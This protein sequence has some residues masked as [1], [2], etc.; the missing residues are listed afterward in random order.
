MKRKLLWTCLFGT[1]VVITGCGGGGGGGGGVSPYPTPNPYLRTEVPYSVPVRVGTVDPL[2]NNS[3]QHFVGDTYTANISGSGQDVIIAG[4]MTQQSSSSDWANT[5]LRMFSWNNGTLVDRTAQWFPDNSN[6]IVGANNVQFADF[7]KS[8][9]TDMVTAPYS[10]W[11]LVNNGPAYV[12]TNRGNSFTRQTLVADVSAHDFAVADVN[13]DGY[14]DIVILDANARNSTLAINDQISSF[15]TYRATTGAQLSGSSL[16]VADFLNNNTTTLITTDNWSANGQVQKLWSWG[17]DSGNNLQWNELATLPTSRFNL[18][19]WKDI[20]ILDSHNVKVSAHD[21]NRDNVMDAIVFSQPGRVMPGTRTDYSEIQFLRN[22]GAGS[23]TDVTDST[24]VGYNTNTRSTY[25]PKF[26]DLNGDGLIDILVSGSDNAG[27]S[28]QF[29]L[30]SADG[31]YVASHAKVLTDYLKQVRDM[32]GGDSFN[33]TVN[34]VTAPDGK[35]HLVSAVSFMNGNDRQLAV[36]LSALGSQSV[37]T[38]QTAVNLMLQK[39]PYMTVAQANDALARTVATYI[40]GVPV[41][42]EDD[43]FKPVGS[44]GLATTRGTVPINGFIAGLNLGDA[45]VIALD[46]VGRSYQM[47]LSSMAVNRLNAFGFN[48]AHNDQHE[49]TSHAE[50]LVNGAVTSVNGFRIGTDW[51][52]RDANNVGMPN[53]PTQYTIGVPSWYKKGSWS[54]GTQ[55]TYLNSN[56]WIAFGGAWGSVNGSG[57]L[58]NVVSYRSRGFSAQ[59]SI[60][61]VSTNINPGLITRVN[62]MWGTWAETGYRFGNVKREGDLGMYAGVKPVVLS[63]SVQAQMP[64]SIDAGGNVVYN[65]KTLMVQNQT[66]G[67]IRALYTNQITKDTQYRFSAVATQQGQ[68]RI[69]NELRWWIK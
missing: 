10:D 21:F 16:A 65:N 57:I 1:V 12:W 62:D 60:M 28:S 46:Q 30:R 38:A 11:S 36:Y 47:N 52:G 34:V 24:L 2:A 43:M 58:D 23:F 49:M 67:Y 56:P 6:V 45:S 9:R 50:Y 63:G 59:A 66:I 41:I 14:T 40:N 64:T 17:I 20:G 7:F 69:M 44:L 61:H 26:L 48:T 3:F 31:K 25:Q 42:N 13:R 37:T 54:M 32:A 55:Y 53:R 8:G 68:Y 39:W 15:V 4:H 18:Q 29:L 35:L 22:N 27:T 5:Q 33:H 51:T 19:K